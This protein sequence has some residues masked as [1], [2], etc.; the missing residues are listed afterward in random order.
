MG[1]Q[2]AQNPGN[3]FFGLAA[4][5]LKEIRALRLNSCR[6]FVIIKGLLVWLPVFFLVLMRCGLKKVPTGFSGVVN[7]YVPALLCCLMNCLIISKVCSFA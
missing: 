1:K 2:S 3:F 6:Q 4:E 5:K 7:H